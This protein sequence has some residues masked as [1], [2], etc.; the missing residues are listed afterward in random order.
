SRW[1]MAMIVPL[2][3]CAK[4]GLF[5]SSRSVPGA[6]GAEIAAFDEDAPGALL[7]KISLHHVRDRGVALGIVA[8]SHAAAIRGDLPAGRLRLIE[9]SADLLRQVAILA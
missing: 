8:E 4:L 7:D 6:D 1:L 3:G 9:Y 2:T 5:V